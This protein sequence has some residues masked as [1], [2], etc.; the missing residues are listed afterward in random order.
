MKCLRIPN[1]VHFKDITDIE[2]A[3]KL[4]K[5]ILRETFKNSFKPD[6]EEEFEDAQGNLYTRKQY[7]DMKRQ[8]LI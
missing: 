5:K 4:H 7:I 3:L 2:H 8:G 1:Q 6:I